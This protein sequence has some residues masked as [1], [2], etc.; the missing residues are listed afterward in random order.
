[1]SP[2]H[3]AASMRAIKAHDGGRVSIAWAKRRVLEAAGETTDRDLLTL[4]GK[5]ERA[6]GCSIDELA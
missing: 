3:L 6:C 4:R 2:L 5:L 1:M